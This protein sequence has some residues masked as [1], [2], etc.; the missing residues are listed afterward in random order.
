MVP[1]EYAVFAGILTDIT[2]EKQNSVM[3]LEGECLGILQPNLAQCLCPTS[4]V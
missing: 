2:W 4:M 3:H 1:S